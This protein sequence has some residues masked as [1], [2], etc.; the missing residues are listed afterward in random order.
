MHRCGHLLQ[1]THVVWSVCLCAAHTVSCANTAELIEMPFGCLF[2]WVHGTVH[3]M[4]SI[5]PTRMITFHGTPCV[6]RPIVAYLPTH[7]KCA[8]PAHEANESILCHEG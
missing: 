5:S 6:G 1:V 8:Y 4:G 2:L 3:V 7:G